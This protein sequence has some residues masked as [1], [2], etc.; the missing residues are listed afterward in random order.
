METADGAAL[1]AVG[2]VD[3]VVAAL[4]RDRAL[5]PATL[6]E[7]AR[8]ANLRD[9]VAHDALE[10][11]SSSG[12]VI[13]VAR[14]PAY[15]DAGAAGELFV[16]VSEQL[17]ESHRVE[18][19]AM[20]VTSLALSRAHGVDEPA[21]IRIL[22]HFVTAGSIASRA[23]YYAR[24]DHRPA[25]TAEQ[26]AFFERLNSCG[27]S[28]PT[29]VPFA[30]VAAAVKTSSISGLRKALDMLLATGQ[31]V[32]VGDD[33]YRESQI[34]TIRARVQG[35]LTEHHR[36]TAAQF[37]DLLGTTRKYAVPLL[38]WLDARG[39]TVRSGD[40]RLLRNKGAVVAGA[41]SR[42]HRGR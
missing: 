6:R 38:E 27:V 18:P 14:P 37:R 28:D 31:L 7:V 16:R 22:E 26:H 34:R 13:A 40:Y 35:Y 3:A 17:A 9:E 30:S 23:G 39:V 19:W 33:L 32:K 24:S 36:M 25:L 1:G 12:I 15:V 41:E 29:P 10:R 42:S 21:L 2:S 4:L 20:G 11:L 5:T 8:D